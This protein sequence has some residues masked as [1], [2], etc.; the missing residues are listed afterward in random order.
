MASCVLFL[1]EKEAVYDGMG[2]FKLPT[3]WVQV[4]STTIVLLF[5]SDTYDKGR[6]ESNQKI[7]G[8][9]T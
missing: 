6:G 1:P 4:L 9:N 5:F 7:S 2:R 8:H 3:F